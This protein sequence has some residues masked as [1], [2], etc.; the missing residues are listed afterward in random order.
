[1]NATKQALSMTEKR[2]MIRGGS[3]VREKDSFG[4]LISQ[5][6]EYY[7]VRTLRDDFVTHTKQCASTVRFTVLF[8]T[9][10]H[11]GEVITLPSYFLPKLIMSHKL[12]ASMSI[13]Y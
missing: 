6:L 9:R 3:E 10:L 12:M 5:L 2:T 1:M 8:L 13:S 11:H 7:Y 4:L